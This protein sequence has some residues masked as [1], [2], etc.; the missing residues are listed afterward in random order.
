MMLY[1]QYVALSIAFLV[2]ALVGSFLNVCILRLPEGLSVVRPPSRC[3]SCGRPV[4]WYENV[5]IV[6]WLALR[7][8]CAGCGLRISALYPAIE[9]A[10]ALGWLASVAAF[11]P[12]LEAL[13]IAVFGTV[14]LG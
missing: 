2:G 11:G 7:A 14:L 1:P 4:R 9:L 6:S 12:T 13:R 5:P 10:V 8:R 3:P